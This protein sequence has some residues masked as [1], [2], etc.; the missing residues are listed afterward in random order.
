MW[1]LLTLVLILVV[2]ALVTPS[3]ATGQ[4]LGPFCSTASPPL[5]QQFKLTLN[6]TAF[7]NWDIEGTISSPERIVTGKFQ[8]TGANT[9]R[10]FLGIGAGQTPDGK[11]S[12]TSLVSGDVNLQ[13]GVATAI[14]QGFINGSGDCGDRTDMSFTP[15]Q[16]PQ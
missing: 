2:A 14:C 5:N 9:A 7:P 16:C 15:V 11:F 6:P 1:K 3:G 8:Q 10:F 12:G 13:T 4:V